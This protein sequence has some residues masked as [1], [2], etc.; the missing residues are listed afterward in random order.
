MSA[1]E[2][3][4]LHRVPASMP[5]ASAAPQR[6]CACGGLAGPQGECAACRARRLGGLEGLGSDHDFS[7]IAVVAAQPLV[8]TGDVE[9]TGDDDL[10]AVDPESPLQH[11]PSCG[12]TAFFLSMV[13][14]P[15]AAG[16]RIPDGKY[17]VARLAKFR[18][19]GLAGK[20]VTVGERFKVLNDPYGLAGKLTPQSAPTTN[21]IFDDCYAIASDKPLPPDFELKVEQNHLVGETVISRNEIT[22]TPSRIGFC[23]YSRLPSCD[24]G[25]R[26]RK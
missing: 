23:A 18:V 5:A 2:L 1:R 14:G 20:E 12:M 6:T 21:G 13:V 25:G 24:F 4:R 3:D 7:R 22:Y 11:A 16:C 15:E 8:S 26:C 10:S 19:S 17:G 9:A